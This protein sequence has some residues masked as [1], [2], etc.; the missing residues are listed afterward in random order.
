MVAESKSTCFLNLSRGRGGL[1]KSE[2]LLDL[3]W[4]PTSLT[5]QTN[6]RPGLAFTLLL[7]P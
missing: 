1:D 3:P 2:N 6:K 5:S 4:S 7:F